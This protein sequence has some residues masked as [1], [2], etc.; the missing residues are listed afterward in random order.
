MTGCAPRS[1]C[2]GQRPGTAVLVLSQY[3]D[4]GYAL[5]LSASPRRA[6]TSSRSA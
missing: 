3:Y 5:D 2:G 4:E 1:S 6:A